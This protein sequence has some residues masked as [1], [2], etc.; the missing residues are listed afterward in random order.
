D[1]YL[2]QYTF[3]LTTVGIYGSA[4][5]LF[6]VFDE[7]VNAS[8]GLIYPSAVRQLDKGNKQALTDLITKSVSFMLFA[9]AA[10]VVILEAGGTRFIITT[11][12][13]ERFADAMPIFNLL[14]LS[15]FFLPFVS[16]SSIINAMKRPMAVVFYIIISVAA[17]I[18]TFLI[19]GQLGTPAL[20]P[21][22]LIAYYSILGTMLY[23]FVKRNLGFP[24]FMIFRAIKDTFYFLK[25]KFLLISRK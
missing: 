25:S 11:F 13:P 20:T 16:L 22:G 8:V 1:V 3:G 19:V 7:A 12:L 17:S 4:K 6:R 9:F 10:A 18:G 23:I 5:T 2:I 21:L 15:A 24:F 14:I